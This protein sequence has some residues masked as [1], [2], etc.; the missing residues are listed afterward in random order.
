MAPFPRYA[1]QGAKGRGRAARHALLAIGHAA[2]R[3][4]SPPD[5]LTVAEVAKWRFAREAVLDWLAGH[6]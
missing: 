2:F 1:E 6:G 4:F 5:V 3:S